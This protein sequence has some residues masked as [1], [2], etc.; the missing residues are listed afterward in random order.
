MLTRR[1]S[2]RVTVTVSDKRSIFKTNH[3][4]ALFLLET[5]QKHTP[6]NLR[7][8]IQII[9]MITQSR[10]A[11]ITLKHDFLTELQNTGARGCVQT[12]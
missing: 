7:S 5:H 2:V 1:R 12:S 6:A 10:R 9:S 11:L 4:E 8:I 3:Q